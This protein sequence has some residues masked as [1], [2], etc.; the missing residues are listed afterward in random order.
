MAARPGGPACRA[1]AHADA[2]RARADDRRRDLF[3]ASSDD[4]EDA[5]HVPASEKPAEAPLR[6]RE[7]LMCSLGS[8]FHICVED[9]IEHMNSECVRPEEL[10]EYLP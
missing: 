7:R 9:E 3:A 2:Q 6:R 5:A 10:R 8:G 1:R 4:P